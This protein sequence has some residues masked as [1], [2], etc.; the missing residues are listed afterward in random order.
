MIPKCIPSIQNATI[1]KGIVIIDRVIIWI[2]IPFGPNNI[3]P[4]IVVSRVFEGNYWTFRTTPVVITGIHI[5][6]VVIRWTSV[7]KIVY[8]VVFEN[9]VVDFSSGFSLATNNLDTV[10]IAFNRII[11]DINSCISYQYLYKNS[12]IPPLN[13]KTCQGDSSCINRDS[14]T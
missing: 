3:I 6:N 4:I 8:C 11:I 1:Q 14:S 2:S 9:V 5:L 10:F 13:D 7:H 12:L